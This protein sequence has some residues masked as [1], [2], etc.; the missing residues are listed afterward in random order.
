MET[1]AFENE[2][3]R[4]TYDRN[5][6]VAAWFDAP[7][8]KLEL[9]EMEKVGK[10]LLAQYK[11]ETAL[12]NVIVSGTPSF[13]EEVRK[14]VTRITSDDALFARASA[15]VLLVEGF[16]GSAVRAFVSTAL[17]ISRTTTPNKVFADFEAAAAWVKLQLDK[18]PIVWTPGDLVG[19][20]R[21]AV[22]DHNKRK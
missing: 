19:I 12:F 3:A 17:V 6:A 4:F 8:V 16:V 21:R 5:V 7:R 9:L 22:G 18:G 20:Q 1:V 10:R 15:H 13:S 14:E 2:I 11:E